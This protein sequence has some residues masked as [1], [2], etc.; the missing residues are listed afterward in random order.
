[1]LSIWIVQ[2]GIDGRVRINVLRKKVSLAERV[3]QYQ[4]T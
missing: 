1:M 2:V 4:L 3:T